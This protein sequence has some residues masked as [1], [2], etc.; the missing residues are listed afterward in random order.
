VW[1]RGGVAAAAGSGDAHAVDA[2]LRQAA[3]RGAARSLALQG[4]VAHASMTRRG[5]LGASRRTSN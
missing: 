2:A 1:R 3:R 5:A 4:G